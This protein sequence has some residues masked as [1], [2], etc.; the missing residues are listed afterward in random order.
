MSNPSFLNQELYELTLES[1]EKLFFLFPTLDF[2]EEQKRAPFEAG[3]QMDF[4][5]SYQGK[6]FIFLYGNLLQKL[7][8]AMLESS[9]GLLSSALQDVL[10]EWNN[11]LCGNILP[12]V[13]GTEALFKMSPPVLATLAD[14]PSSDSSLKNI[15]TVL[16]PLETGRIEIQLWLQPLT[17]P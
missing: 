15:S 6:M 17:S 2:G 14:L 3:S 1:L 7:A 13:A 12:F 11:I 5:G 4:V 8:T 10:N 16:V 9:E